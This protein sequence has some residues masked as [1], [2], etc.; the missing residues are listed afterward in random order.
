V[1]RSRLTSP[2]FAIVLEARRVEIIRK[3]AMSVVAKIFPTV[4][5]RGGSD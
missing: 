2:L 5:Q 3:Q 1:M 4:V